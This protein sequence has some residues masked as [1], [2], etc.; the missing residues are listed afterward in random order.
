MKITTLFCALLLVA[1]SA[2][3]AL[4][5]PAVG[6]GESGVGNLQPISAG[7]ITPPA[8][9]CHANPDQ[10][11]VAGAQARMRLIDRAVRC[12]DLAAAREQAQ[13]LLA[14]LDDQVSVTPMG[15]CY[16]DRKCQKRVANNLT[17]KDMCK[18]ANGRSW[19]ESTPNAG[20]CELI[21]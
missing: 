3:A 4:T 17:T 5:L 15:I 16:E 9:V 10:E 20:T 19:A 6:E 13:E 7:P 21:R 1:A 12:G 2:R 18:A 8:S 11:Q 14:D